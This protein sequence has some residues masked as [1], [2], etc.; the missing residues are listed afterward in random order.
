M[1]SSKYFRNTFNELFKSAREIGE[2]QII[3]DVGQSVNLQS[4]VD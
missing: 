2:T 1:N 4:K 3:I